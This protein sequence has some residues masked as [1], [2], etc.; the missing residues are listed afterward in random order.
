[1]VNHIVR[2]K[3]MQSQSLTKIVYKQL[4]VIRII[5]KNVDEIF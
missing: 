2:E 1:M 3:S 4:T 5:F